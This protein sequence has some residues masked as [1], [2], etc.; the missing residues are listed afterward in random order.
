MGEKFGYHHQFLVDSAKEVFTALAANFQDFRSYLLESSNHGVGYQ[1]LLDEIA[2]NEEELSVA[3]P[4]QFMVIAPVIMGSGSIGKIIAGIAIIAFTAFVPFSIGLLGAG[5]IS[6]T[7]IGAALLLSGVSQLLAEG[8]KDGKNVQSTAVGT[9]GTI[10]EGD[11]VPIAYGRV[12]LSGNLIS[13]GTT[14]NRR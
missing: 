8:K 2:C 1:V 9:A 3:K 7:S 12:F 10:S 5:I 11:V 6:G 13:A 4:P 14:V